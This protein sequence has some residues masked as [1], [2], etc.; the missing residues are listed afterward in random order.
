M[1]RNAVE[2]FDGTAAADASHIRA[3][4]FDLDGVL[5][6]E[7]DATRQAFEATCA[8]AVATDDPSHQLLVTAVRSVA[9]SLWQTGPA[10]AYCRQ[11]GASSSEGLCATFSGD[12]DELR[13]LRA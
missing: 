3:I 1:K 6:P 7:D 9:R 2:N 13:V 11:I 10:A 5:I 8:L 12:G 4:V